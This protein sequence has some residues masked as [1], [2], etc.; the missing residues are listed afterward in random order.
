MRACK[1]DGDEMVKSWWV[2]LV[3]TEDKAVLI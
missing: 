1:N 2:L 3:N